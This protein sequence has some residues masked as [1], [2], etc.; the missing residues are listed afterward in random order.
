MQ[1]GHAKQD[2]SIK[3]LPLPQQ[4]M[5]LEKSI[6]PYIFWKCLLYHNEEQKYNKLQEAI[7]PKYKYILDKTC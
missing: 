2:K 5:E 6:S 3:C 1:L 7:V 4:S